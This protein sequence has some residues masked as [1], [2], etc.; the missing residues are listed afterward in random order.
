MCVCKYDFVNVP[1][2]SNINESKLISLEWEPRARWNTWAIPY[3]DRCT[4]DFS[5]FCVCKW[6]SKTTLSVHLTSFHFSLWFSLLLSVCV[7]LQCAFARMRLNFHFFSA[8]A[9]IKPNV[10]VDSIQSE[11]I[12]SERRKKIKTSAQKI[13]LNKCVHL[14]ITIVVVV[15]LLARS[16]A[17][18]CLALIAILVCSE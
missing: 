18:L 4:V 16:L 6:T 10:R 11:S 5:P 7:C 8:S 1:N 15:H 9:K 2:K 17:C 14:F 13:S 3:C 12:S